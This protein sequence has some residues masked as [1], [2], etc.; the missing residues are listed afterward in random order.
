MKTAQKNYYFDFGFDFIKGIANIK[1]D[2][3]FCKELDINY[4]DYIQNPTKIYF[5][6]ILV[7]C[8]ERII[9][10]EYVFG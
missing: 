8:R 1:T 3:E 9:N 7:Y 2:V 10:L 4:K 5:E 6:N